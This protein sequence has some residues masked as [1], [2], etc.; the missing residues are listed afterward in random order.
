MKKEIKVEV[1]T[2][3]SDI[4][5]R[6]YLDLQVDLEAYEGDEEATT[7][8]LFNH[9]CSFDINLIPKLSLASYNLLK[10]KL[11]NLVNPTDVPLTKFV[12]IAGIEY[13]FE[14]NLSQ[15]SYGAYADISSFEILKID[16]NWAKVMNILY[17]PV[18]LKTHNLYEIQ[19]Y[20]GD[21]NWE[22]WLEVDMS[23]HFGCW[24]FFIN[25]QTDLLNVILNYMKE[26]ELP[27]NIS[28]ILAKSGKLMQQ[29]LNLRMETL[30]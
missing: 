26:V 11:N 17:R 3:W 29:S 19:T 22:K 5:L 14:P 20:D 13:G 8:A 12:N 23:V 10:S 9:L 4:T 21:E 16:K 15:I 28:S 30:K 27:P 18:K 7:A 6:K 2:S 25:L 24:F 1:P